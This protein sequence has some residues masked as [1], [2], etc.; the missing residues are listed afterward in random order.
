[1]RDSNSC[2]AKQCYE[3]LS[4]ED[5]RRYKKLINDGANHEMK[6]KVLAWINIDMLLKV[7]G[8]ADGDPLEIIKW[9]SELCNDLLQE[10]NRN[11]LRV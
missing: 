4:D 1:M 5:K 11:E 8:L 7:N 2:Q 3:S 6:K 10:A 9:L